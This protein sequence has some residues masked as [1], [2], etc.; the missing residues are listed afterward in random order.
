MDVGA[1]Q[2]LWRRGNAAAA[3]KFSAGNADGLTAGMSGTAHILIANSKGHDGHVFREAVVVG[4]VQAQQ[5]VKVGHPS[6]W[7]RALRL[8][9]GQAAFRTAAMAR[10]PP[11]APAFPP[12]AAAATAADAAARPQPQPT[13]SPADAAPSGRR[14][15]E[16]DSG[17]SDDSHGGGSG[18]DGG[19][20][21]GGDTGSGGGLAA[22]QPGATP[23][24]K[25]VKYD[26]PRAHRSQDGRRLS[27]LSQVF[28]PLVHGCPVASPLRSHLR[29]DW[30]KA[31]V[32]L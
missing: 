12:T 32:N 22:P 11:E 25:R 16:G 4:R 6:P 3:V 15:P 29:C 27:E 19:N 17:S 5:P 2:W 20:E 28:S 18:G 31:A 21:S 10:F 30:P 24:S 23:V 7:L 9:A 13:G 26:D 14:P 1:R 8:A